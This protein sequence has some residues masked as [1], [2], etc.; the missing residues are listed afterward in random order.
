MKN[1]N[2]GVGLFKCLQLDT[3]VLNASAIMGYVPL[4]VVFII[5]AVAW[6]KLLQ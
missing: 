5:A 2:L 6:P 3:G 1:N 4:R